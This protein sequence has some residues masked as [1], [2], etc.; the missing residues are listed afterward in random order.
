MLRVSHQFFPDF[1]ENRLVSE[2][3]DPFPSLLVGWV[4]PQWLYALLLTMRWGGVNGNVAV[5][6]GQMLLNITIGERGAG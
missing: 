6:K 1:V 5:D 2:G 3:Q 4:L